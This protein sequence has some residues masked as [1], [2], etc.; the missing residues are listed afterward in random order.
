MANSSQ[1]RPE[2]AG[3][4]LAPIL[5]CPASNDY[6]SRLPP[7][8][9]EHIIAAGHIVAAAGFTFSA[10]AASTAK[11]S[12]LP[13][14]GAA[15]FVMV[16]SL[17]LILLSRSYSAKTPYTLEGVDMSLLAAIL[18]V[19]NALASV[20]T[21]CAP[22]KVFTFIAFSAL[23]VTANWLEMVANATTPTLPRFVALKATVLGAGDGYVAAIV[24]GAQAIAAPLWPAFVVKAAINVM[25]AGAAIRTIL[26]RDAAH[27][28]TTSAHRKNE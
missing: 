21:L 1:G 6:M 27:R 4:A 26:A 5:T 17:R 8:A 11:G 10:V 9:S 28:T 7:L 18:F 14:Y 22:D 15:L 16:V 19:S 24:A 23:D 25:S 2:E 12:R 3:P 13:A 20:G